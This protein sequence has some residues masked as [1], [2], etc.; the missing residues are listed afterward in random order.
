MSKVRLLVGTKQGRVCADVGW[1]AREVGGE[2]AALCGVGDLSREGIA[3]GSE[4]VVCV[5]VE[6][7]VW[8]DDSALE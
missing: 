1:E 6:R 5:A 7:M 3:G 2:W 8:A 4:P